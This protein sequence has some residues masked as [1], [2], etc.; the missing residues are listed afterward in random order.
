MIVYT[1]QE[2]SEF[3]RPCGLDM[4]IPTLDTAN[5]L[6]RYLQYNSFLTEDTFSYS[7]SR[8]KLDLGQTV[9]T[10]ESLDQIARAQKSWQIDLHACKSW[11]I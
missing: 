4:S 3:N 6:L 5:I 2:N 9:D 11:H 1:C 7:W 8:I 10:L